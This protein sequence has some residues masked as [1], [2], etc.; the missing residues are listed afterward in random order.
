MY[1]KGNSVSRQ[2]THLNN[3]MFSTQFWKFN[4]CTS[5]CSVAG[6]HDVLKDKVKACN[7]KVYGNIAMTFVTFYD[8]RQFCVILCFPGQWN[9]S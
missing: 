4:T 2:K 8:G 1:F 3:V 6:G 5:I 9:P 7:F